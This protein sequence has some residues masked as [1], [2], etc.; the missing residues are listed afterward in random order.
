[1]WKILMTEMV[2]ET[3]PDHFFFYLLITRYIFPL[4]FFGH[5]DCKPSDEENPTTRAVER[6]CSS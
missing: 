2:C 5:L 3:R 4:L 1:M 6:D